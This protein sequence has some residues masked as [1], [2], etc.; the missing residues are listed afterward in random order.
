MI[1]RNPGVGC[2]PPQMKTLVALYRR[3]Y[4]LVG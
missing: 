1:L 4:G 2:M 3:M